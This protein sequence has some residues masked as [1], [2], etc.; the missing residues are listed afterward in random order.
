L[1][2]YSLDPS[3]KDV[4]INI[5]GVFGTDTF[6]PYLNRTMKTPNGFEALFSLAMWAQVKNPSM[7]I[8]DIDNV[9]MSGLN[10][11]LKSVN[12][13]IGFFTKT[14]ANQKKDIVTIGDVYIV[15]VSKT[16]SK[17]SKYHSRS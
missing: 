17:I 14:G 9:Y 11:A 7:K 13:A 2:I 6:N 3:Q 8:V 16:F 15:R 10:E 1:T 12:Y 5:T 4:A